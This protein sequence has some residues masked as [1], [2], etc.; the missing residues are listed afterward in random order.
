MKGG[1]RGEV[2]IHTQDTLA[3]LSLSFIPSLALLFLVRSRLSL[4]FP[5]LSHLSPLSSRSSFMTMNAG[6]LLANSL[7]SGKAICRSC[8]R[9][10]LPA[11][12]PPITLSFRVPHSSNSDS[13]LPLFHS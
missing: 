6:E 7:S 11:P 1:G 9:T 8:G 5:F 10:V 4:I 2:H 13:H 12:P 3:C